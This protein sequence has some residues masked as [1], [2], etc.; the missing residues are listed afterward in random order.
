MTVNPWPNGLGWDVGDDAGDELW[1][2]SCRVIGRRE[3]GGADIART[4]RPE[5]PGADEGG[6]GRMWAREWPNR[7]GWDVGEPRPGTS[8]SAVLERRQVRGGVA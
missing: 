4:G 1:G 6:E 5:A 7:Q 2:Y 3:A 8:S